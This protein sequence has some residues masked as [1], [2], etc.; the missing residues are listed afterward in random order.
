MWCKVV[1]GVVVQAPGGI[2]EGETE[3][4]GW[5]PV[6]DVGPWPGPDETGDVTLTV[7]GDLVERS[8]ANIRPVVA[9]VDATLLRRRE[10]LAAVVAARPDDPVVAAL[11]ELVDALA[12]P[13]WR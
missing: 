3:A 9:P 4:D 1:D 8:W 7:R 13:E 5:L 2:A 12:L 10:A 6:L 11:A